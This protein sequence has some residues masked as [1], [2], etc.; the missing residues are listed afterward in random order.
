MNLH[1]PE[2]LEW[3]KEVFGVGGRIEWALSRRESLYIINVPR[4]VGKTTGL[5]LWALVWER[6]ALA[7]GHIGIFA[8]SQKHLA[9]IGDKLKRYAGEAISGPSPGGIGW[10][11]VSG[12]RIDLWPLGSGAI[13]AGRGRSYEGLLVDE[14]AYVPDLM[15]VLEGNLTPTLATTG[16]PAILLSTPN[17]IN[18]DYHTLWRRTPAR[19]R[20]SADQSE[21]DPASWLNPAIKPEWLAEKRR[22]MLELGYRQEHEAAFVDTTGLKLRRSEVKYGKPPELSE[23]R[24]IS[25]AID[26]ATSE[27]TS[28]DYTAIAICGVDRQDRRWLLHLAHWRLSWGQSV[29]KLLGYHQSWRPHVTIFEAVNF[30]SLGCRELLNAGMACRPIVPHKD[31]LTRFERLHVRYHMGEIWHSDTLDPECENELY[32]F[33]S[34]AH[35]DCVDAAVYAFAP[36]FAELA[37]DWAED[38][39]SGEQWGSVGKLPHETIKRVRMYGQGPM[40]TETYED[41]FYDADGQRVDEQGKPHQ[42]VLPSFSEG[43]VGDWLIVTSSDGK[44]LMRIERGKSHLYFGQKM[45]GQLPWQQQQPN[46]G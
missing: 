36:L 44:E 22:T 27:K 2:P 5:L 8:P 42:V 45:A 24:T 1:L 35:D 7:G 9:D 18:D 21:P 28:A 39:S 33:D 32:A 37:T 16:G 20:F 34:G 13:A 10:D 26:P 25:M 23:L 15:A 46:N 12:G 40:Y 38:R 30:A 43:F 11:F 14:A 19:A 3:Q 31:K 17:G 41:H 4:Q 6:G 29:E